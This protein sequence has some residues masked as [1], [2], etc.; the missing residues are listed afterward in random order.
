MTGR[1]RTRAEAPSAPRDAAPSRLEE[2]E[3]PESPLPPPST[4]SD[5]TPASG[6]EPLSATSDESPLARA[7]LAPPLTRENPSPRV[8]ARAESN[9]GRVGAAVAT[10]GG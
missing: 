3:P 5:V 8:A 6:I 10:W 1:M 4:V 9:K 7:A 2:S